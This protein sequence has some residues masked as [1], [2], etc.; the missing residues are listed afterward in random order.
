MTFRRLWGGAGRAWD[1][2]PLREPWRVLVPLMV[3]HWIALVLYTASVRHNGWLFYQ[4]GDQIWYWTT[5]WLLGHGSITVPSVSHG[6]SL[7]LVPLTWIGGPGFLAGLEGMLLLQAL[8]L[9]P[10]A[11]WCMYE[12]GARIG[13]RVIGYA[14]A[15]LWTLGPYVVIPLFVHRYHEKYVEQFLPQDRS[16]IRRARGVRHEAAGQDMRDVGIG[17]GRAETGHRLDMAQGADHRR[18]VEVE[19]D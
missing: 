2:M 4:G 9:A 12:L 7:L 19:I 1:R 14:A 6:W 11:L 16:P 3:V 17:E 15:A 5:G 10:I 8:V 13:G 18:L